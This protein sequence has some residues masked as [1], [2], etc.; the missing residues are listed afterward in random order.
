[1]LRLIG[2]GLSATTFAISV[3]VHCSTFVPGWSVGMNRAWPL[4]L[5]AMLSVGMLI[6]SLMFLAPKSTRRD[7]EGSWD[8]L[9]RSRSESQAVWHRMLSITP[10]WVKVAGV[11]FIGYAF[12]NFVLFISKMDGGSP[13]ERNGVYVL[14]NH[15]QPIRDLTK[16]EY[17]QFQ[18][19]IARGFSGHWL[20]FSFLP[21][22]YFA[23]V[24]PRLAAGYSQSSAGKSSNLV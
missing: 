2:L 18:A 19:Y 17:E 1:V 16:E 23:F 21:F 4:H 6:F 5:A 13:N 7:S 20:V 10:A 15:G 14:E 3:L 24:Q 9:I 8:Y 11:L 22:A 12:V